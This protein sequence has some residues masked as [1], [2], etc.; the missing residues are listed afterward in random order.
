M[1]GGA[2][3]G[4]SLLLLAAE[5]AAR[6]CATLHYFLAGRLLWGWVT[7]A[8]LLPGYLA[9]GLSFVWF[10]A[11]GRRSSGSLVLIH[12]LQ[13]GIWKRYWDALRSALKA[14]GPP[15]TR[16][17]TMQQGDLAVL[18]LLEALLQTLP[19]LLLQA[20]SCVLM[21]AQGVVSGLSAGIGLLSFSWALVSYS[22]FTRL[23]RPGRLS[24]PGA[25]LLCQLLWRT[26][27]IGSRV[28][29]LVL[30]AKVYHLWVFVAAGAHWLVMSYWV[31]AQHTDIFRNPCHWRIF[32]CLTGAVYVFCYISFKDGPSLYRI[33]VYYAM[34]ALENSLLLLMVGNVRNGQWLI[35]IVI[36][37]FI[38]AFKRKIR[39]S[40]IGEIDVANPSMP[41]DESG[42]GSSALVTY[43]SWLHPKSTE[44]WQ[45]FL[46]RACS[47]GPRGTKTTGVSS[48]PQSSDQTISNTGIAGWRNNEVLS[49]ETATPSLG[50]S[51]GSS[52]VELGS[53]RDV[54]DPWETHHHWL[55]V[56]LAMKTGDISK[57]NAAFGEGGIGELYHIA[58]A[59]QNSAAKLGPRK[60]LVFSTA[61]GCPIS[62]QAVWRNS[63]KEEDKAAD[64]LS[65]QEE[66]SLVALPAAKPIA[67]ETLPH[68]L[69]SAI[70]PSLETPSVGPDLNDMCECHSGRRRD[71][72]SQER[73]SK[74]HGEQQMPLHT[75]STVYFT[76]SIEVGCSKDEEHKKVAS[77]PAKNSSVQGSQVD[78]GGGFLLTAG[79]I[80]SISTSTNRCLQSSPVCCLQSSFDTSTSPESADQQGMLR[81]HCNSSDLNH[82]G[83]WVAVLKGNR[84]TVEKPQLTS[85][86]KMVTTSQ[87]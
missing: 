84:G 34:M 50:M 2:F 55:L 20:Y 23:I 69:S 63:L 22:R 68:K 35:G 32:N 27:M 86:P 13:L 56:K 8:L 7:L 47:V 28:V 66:G 83:T 25:A 30:F 38:V 48:A 82:F 16:E 10:R 12:L 80:S 1:R 75:D 70:N 87:E 29:T 77:V 26:G 15:G 4:L 43:Y 73:H 6:F 3:A 60:K 14:G 79:N 81:L 61:E 57:I 85:T 65:S 19:N 33:T 46:K 64:R 18:R 45:D 54:G 58:V 17:L 5:Q 62:S 9:Q 72:V 51:H 71:P 36:S 44:I 78:R 59:E 31:A 74:R 67:A 42:E 11:D 53:R 21:E 37:G 40:V 39:A 52:L 76:A 49:V 24:M 41:K